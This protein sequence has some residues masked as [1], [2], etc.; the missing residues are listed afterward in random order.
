MRILGL[1]L[2]LGAGAVAVGVIVAGPP[3]A[4]VARPML[5]VGLKRGVEIYAE[6]RTRLEAAIED[7][8]DLVAEVHEEVV[9]A[10]NVTPHAANEDGAASER[11]RA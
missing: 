2:F 4:R 10:R 3:L 9:Q 6:A 7:L 5:R 8:S 11:V 1:A